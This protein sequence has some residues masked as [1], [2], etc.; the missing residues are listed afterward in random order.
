MCFWREEL[1]AGGILD[2]RRP[3]ESTALMVDSGP[4]TYGISNQR[5][6]HSDE[7]FNLLNLKAFVQEERTKCL[8][9]YNQP[10]LVPRQPGRNNAHNGHNHTT[11]LRFSFPL[12]R[13]EREREFSLE[14]V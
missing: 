6:T 9:K 4:A 13:Q 1:R 5:D 11:S 14:C 3:S 7:T 8:F 10:T 2:C 12:A